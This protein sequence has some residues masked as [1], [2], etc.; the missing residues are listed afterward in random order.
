MKK[1]HVWRINYCGKWYKQLHTWNCKNVLKITE[2]NEI[3][4]VNKNLKNPW[5]HHN[6][7]HQ[8]KNWPVV[9]L[10]GRTIVGEKN[11]GDTITNFPFF[12]SFIS[13]RTRWP[14]NFGKYNPV[15][16]DFSLKLSCILQQTWKK[17]CKPVQ[18][19]P[20]LFQSSDLGPIG[21]STCGRRGAHG[22]TRV[23]T[24]SDYDRQDYFQILYCC[25]DI[26]V[27]VL[28][29]KCQKQKIHGEFGSTESLVRFLI[30][31]L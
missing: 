8:N 30:S 18:K 4:T 5:A 3:G 23:G 14:H 27:T 15:T 31:A 26:V 28:K 17:L 24:T 20:N 1:L 9:W 10:S 29:L 16:T 11:R 19:F 12:L 25:R 7:Y 21:F 22:V 6:K 2:F 13:S